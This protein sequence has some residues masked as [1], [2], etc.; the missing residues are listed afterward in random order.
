MTTGMNTWIG[1]GAL[2]PD[3]NSIIRYD[4]A[5]RKS[6]E[7]SSRLMM[8]PHLLKTPWVKGFNLKKKLQKL[9]LIHKLPIYIIASSGLCVA[10]NWSG[11]LNHLSIT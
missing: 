10:E 11:E 6:S 5:V 4:I 8:Q 1:Y 9:R 7:E 2:R 3:I